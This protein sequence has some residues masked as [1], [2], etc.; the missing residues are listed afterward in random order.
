MPVYLG[1]NNNIFEVDYESFHN[2]NEYWR[3]VIDKKFNTK[4]KN[5]TSA[6]DMLKSEVNSI[7]EKHNKGNNKYS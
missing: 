7:Y 5:S 1:L 4:S 3:I 6:F 2:K